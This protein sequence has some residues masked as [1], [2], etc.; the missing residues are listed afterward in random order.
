MPEPEGRKVKGGERAAARTTSTVYNDVNLSVQTSQSGTQAASLV[1]TTYYDPLGRVRLTAD[2]LGDKVEKAYRYG[3]GMSYELQSNPY[4]STS[5]PTMGWTMTTHDSVGRAVAVN[6]Y[7]G[8]TPPAPW[9]SNTTT[10]GTSTA[11]Y[12]QTLAGCAGPVTNA[13]D[14]AGNMNSSCAD[15]LGRLAS[16]TEPN[17]VSG[18]AGTVTSYTLL[19][20]RQP[21]TARFPAVPRCICAASR[22]A[23]CRG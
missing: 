6:H 4:V 9:G 5:D 12:D 23:R 22:T 14:E 21:R 2:G 18:S 10:T 17:P 13:T 1:S 11:A 19:R 8:S 15:G 7:P 3:M 16:V 20:G